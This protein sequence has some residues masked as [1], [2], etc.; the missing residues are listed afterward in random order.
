MA[1]FTRYGTGCLNSFETNA[2]IFLIGIMGCLYGLE[3]P[4]EANQDA[5]VL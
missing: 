2:T 5:L 3:L 4:C 1:L